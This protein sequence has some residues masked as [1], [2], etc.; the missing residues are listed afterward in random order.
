MNRWRLE[1]KNEQKNQEFH[2][3]EQDQK[4]ELEREKSAIDAEREIIL[5][6]RKVFEREKAEWDSRQLSSTYRNSK[7]MESL[8]KKNKFKFSLGAINFGNQ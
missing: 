6:E 8:R 7:S 4:K 3:F 1:N 2:L 5:S